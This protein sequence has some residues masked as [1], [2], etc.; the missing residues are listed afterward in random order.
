MFLSKTDHMK[1]HR[2]MVYDQER[3]MYRRIDGVL[4]DT[5]DKHL[6][7]YNRIK[8]FERATGIEPAFYTWEEL[9]VTITLYPLKCADW[10]GRNDSLLNEGRQPW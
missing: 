1:L 9:R 7:Y 8:S 6:E 3:R 10:H 2:Y 4:L 5:K